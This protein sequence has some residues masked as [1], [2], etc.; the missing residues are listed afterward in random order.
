MSVSWKSNLKSSL[1]NYSAD[2]DQTRAKAEQSRTIGLHRQ[3]APRPL[4]T[5]SAV[6]PEEVTK[7]AKKTAAKRRERGGEKEKE[8]AAQ[9]GMAH[10]SEETKGVW[11]RSVKRT[12]AY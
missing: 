1:F 3:R 4:W 10:K 12:C 5:L 8:A 7:A 6:W 2:V 11:Q 9:S